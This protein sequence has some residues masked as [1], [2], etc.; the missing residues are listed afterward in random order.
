M[1]ISKPFCIYE[2]N[3][4]AHYM[5][6]MTG[7]SNNYQKERMYLEMKDHFDE[8]WKSEQKQNDIM[9]ALKNDAHG[10][11]TVIFRNPVEN[12]HSGMTTNMQK[13]MKPKKIPIK[14]TKTSS[15]K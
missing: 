7:D 2:I 15:R 13:I 14:K 9:I 12:T 10:D 3:E 5:E 6:V 4:T 11:T 8:I 1:K